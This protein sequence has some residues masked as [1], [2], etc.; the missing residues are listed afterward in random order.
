MW[1]LASHLPSLDSDEILA[2]HNTVTLP[3]P[4]TSNAKAEGRFG[5]QDFRYVAEEDIY[6]CPAGKSLAYSFTTSENGLVLRRYSTKACHSCRIKNSCTTS[7][8]RRITR[9]IFSGCSSSRRC[10]AS[11]TCSCSHQRR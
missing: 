2:C 3:K 7:K 11:R 8:E 5:K 10:T 4:M 1:T 9:R 6:V